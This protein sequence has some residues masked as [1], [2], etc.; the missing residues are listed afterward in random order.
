MLWRGARCATDVRNLCAVSRP[1]RGLRYGQL[2][3]H[4]LGY[5]RV[6]TLEQSPDL[7]V[8]TDCCGLLA[9]VDRPCVKIGRFDPAY[10][11]QLGTYSRS[12]TIGCGAATGT[13]RRSGSC[14]ARAVT[15]RWSATPWPARPPRWLSRTTPTTACR[16]RSAVG[17][18]PPPSSPPPSSL[19][20]R[21][22]RRVVTAGASRLTATRRDP[23]TTH[24]SVKPPT[25]A[26]PNQDPNKSRTDRPITHAQTGPRSS[27]PLSAPVKPVRRIQAE[28]GLHAP[29]PPA[30]ID[31]GGVDPDPPRTLGSRQPCPST[32]TRI[33]GPW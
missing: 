17:C 5:A 6:S 26:R 12:S 2:M 21:R 16:R 24:R 13:P 31:T 20:R 28:P 8:D 3:A 7:Q 1:R 15:T 23:G 25:A 18:P 33:E 22:P 11:G 32:Q 27:S 14:C 30:W 4:L 29:T 10:V 9:G 19:L